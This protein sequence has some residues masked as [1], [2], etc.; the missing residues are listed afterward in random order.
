MH[1]L[2]VGLG[3]LEASLPEDP[4]LRDFDGLK[5][6]SEG[7]FDDDDLVRILTD[8]IEDLAGKW[9]KLWMKACTNFH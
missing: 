3:K 5:R 9:V 7:K 6:D 4:L 2:L 1:E 8:S